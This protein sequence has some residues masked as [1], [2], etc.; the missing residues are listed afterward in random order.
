MHKRETTRHAGLVGEECFEL[1][2]ALQPLRV[3]LA[4]RDRAIQ[5]GLLCLRED[6]F[7]GL[8]EVF[9]FHQFLGLGT[10]VTFADHD[11]A[12]FDVAGSHLDAQWH[13][14]LDPLPVARAAGQVALVHMHADRLAAEGVA[15]QRLGQC[16]AGIDHRI[17]RV[18]LRCDWQDNDLLWGHAWWQHDAIVVAMRHDQRANGACADPPGSSPRELLLVVATKEFNVRGLGKVLPQEVRCARLDRLPILHHCFYR[19]GVQRARET[20]A[21]CLFACDGWDGEEV[22]QEVGIHLVH[23]LGFH[24]RFLGGFMRSVA[25]LP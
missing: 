9:L 10:F 11:G 8:E 15:A 3:L 19:E 6:V 1:V 21:R 23:Q 12:A 14:L 2:E 20:L 22:A 24:H 17:A 16:L 7:H 25:F 13:A 18:G 4:I 5:Q